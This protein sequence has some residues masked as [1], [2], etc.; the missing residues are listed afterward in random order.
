[1][2]LLMCS[3]EMY[4][5]KYEINPWMHTHVVP[6]LDLAKIQ[7]QA[8]KTALEEA[9]AEICLI[10]AQPNQPDM[11]FTANGGLVFKG[12]AILANFR[13][14]ER[15]GEAPAFADWFLSQQLKLRVLDASTCFEGEGDGDGLIMGNRLF[16]AYRQRT[17]LAAHKRISQWLDIQVISLLLINPYFYHLDTCFF[18]LDQDTALYYPGAFDGTSLQV[19]S[20]WVKHLVPIEDTD[21]LSFGANGVVV[22]RKVILPFIS[23]GL[24]ETIKDLGYQPVLLDFSEFMKAG[25][26]AKCLV[27][28]LEH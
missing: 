3:P 9:G 16:A 27:L 20:Q 8:Y 15:S 10:R 26:A 23:F 19:L 24:Q 18:P 5:V 11:V 17:D 14:L 22:G 2:K 25:G 13:F 21:A 28:Q 1:M 6:D 4:G 12:Q 7:W